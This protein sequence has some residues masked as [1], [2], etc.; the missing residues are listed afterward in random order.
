MVNIS[1]HPFWNSSWPV[2]IIGGTIAGVL[3]AVIVPWLLGT[4]TSGATK[5]SQMPTVSR[6]GQPPST[7]QSSAYSPPPS[8]SPIR[9]WG[10]GTTRVGGGL[11]LDS[12]PP[13]ANATGINTDVFLSNGDPSASQPLA[14]PGANEALWTES[15]APSESDCAKLVMTQGVG[16]GNPVTVK[17]GSIVCVSTDQGNVAI[18]VV[19]RLVSSDVDPAEIVEATVWTVPRQ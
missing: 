5:A 15:G 4:G 3:V 19:K 6:G 7:S 11:D 16:P 9:Q 18:L 8:P 2:T 17:P 1:R 14:N 12:V 13:N 10:P